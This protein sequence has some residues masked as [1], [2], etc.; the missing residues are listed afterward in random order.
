MNH[1][2]DN[3]AF[4]GLVG[5]DFVG[6]GIVELPADPNADVFS[7]RTDDSGV[8]DDILDAGFKEK[9]GCF[10]HNIYLAQK[11]AFEDPDDELIEKKD[12]NLIFASDVKNSTSLSTKTVITND[13]NNKVNKK[14]KLNIGE[15]MMFKLM[16]KVSGLDNLSEIFHIAH[17]V[18]KD[19]KGEKGLTDEDIVKFNE[20]LIEVL[21]SKLKES[22]FSVDSVFTLTNEEKLEA[23]TEARKEEK[24]AGD[25]VADTFKTDLDNM[26]TERDSLS[27]EVELLKTRITELETA[28]KD[29]EVK[30]KIDEFIDGMGLESLTGSMRDRLHAMAM[31][32]VKD[33]EIDE[34]ALKAFAEDIKVSFNQAELI[35]ASGAMGGGSAGGDNKGNDLEKELK[36]ISKEYNK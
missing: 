21:S 25:I 7:L 14:D 3:D 13:N 6:N 12:L 11:A 27:N 33:G 22:D 2:N 5:I 20:E 4:R 32:N 30:A 26:K 9:H 31:N 24:K 35:K 10:S 23:I 19:F 16:E 15:N 29:K 28:E 36:T 34:E 8:I 1:Q 17:T 18:L